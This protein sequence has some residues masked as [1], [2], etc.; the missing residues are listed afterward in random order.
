MELPLD[1]ER[2]ETWNQRE[3]SD[4]FALARSEGPGIRLSLALQ[5]SAL[6]MR[7]NRAATPSACE[8]ELND[9][10]RLYAAPLRALIHP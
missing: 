4:E 7:L 9:K 1:R 10:T 5:L 6:A 3:R 2:L 8:S